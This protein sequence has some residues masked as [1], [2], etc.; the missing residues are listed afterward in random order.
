MNDG[1]LGDNPQL[2]GMSMYP[3][4]VDATTSEEDKQAIKA[5]WSLNLHAQPCTDILSGTDFLFE[6]YGGKPTQGCAAGPYW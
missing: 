1:R 3:W 4:L 2:D 6:Y 5:N